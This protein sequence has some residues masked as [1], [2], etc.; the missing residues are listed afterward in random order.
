M[1]VHCETGWWVSSCVHGCVCVCVCVW[2]GWTTL[3]LWYMNTARG[4]WWI[5]WW[6]TPHTQ[7]T[8]SLS[9][10]WPSLTELSTNP[11][12]SIPTL[13]HDHT[14]VRWHGWWDHIQVMRSQRWRDHRD[15]THRWWD[16]TCVMQPL[17]A[18]SVVMRSTDRISFPA[19]HCQTQYWD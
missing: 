10:N 19:N 4:C 17:A 13:Q 7:S 6:S 16:H 8:I 9:L 18:I 15:H 2:Q 11:A 5:Y 1:D 14:Q 12:V 3:D